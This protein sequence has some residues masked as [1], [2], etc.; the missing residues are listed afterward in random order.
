MVD[1]L[2]G[3]TKKLPP[4]PLSAAENYIA[5]KDLLVGDVNRALTEHP[6]LKILIGSNPLTV[7]YDNHNNHALFMGNVFKLNDFTFMARVIFWV[8]RTYN[9]RGF[10]FDYFPAALNAWVEAIKKHIEPEQAKHLINIY[11]WM[12][13]NHEEIIQASEKVTAPPVS[14]NPEWNDLKESFQASLLSGNHRQSLNIAGD[15]VHK[16]EDLADFYLQVIQPSMYAIGNLWEKGDISVAQEHLASAIV[17]RVMAS[18]YPRFILLEHTKGKSIVTAAPNEFHEIGPR[19]VADLL[20]INGWDVDYIGANVPAKDILDLV[21]EKEPFFV[22]ISVG[23]PFN[24]DNARDIIDTLKSKPSAKNTKIMLGGY[25]F[26]DNPQLIEK[27]GA[28]GYGASAKEAVAV[29]NEWWADN[30]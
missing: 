21:L 18:L 5:K 24:I 4:V 8:Y 14:I 23:T 13:D 3:S 29:A 7:L 15:A 10:S 27:L 9:Q 17:T 28:E 30:V 12:I 1:A 6:N 11:R 16:P 25:C 2:I 20:E 19:M 22:A 26:L